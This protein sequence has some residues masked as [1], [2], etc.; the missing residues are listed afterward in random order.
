MSHLQKIDDKIAEMIADLNFSPWKLSGK[1]CEGKK[2]G[3]V[4][5]ALGMSATITQCRYSRY[6]DDRFCYFCEK[7]AQGLF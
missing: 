3:S 4:Q 7:K 1:R 5:G 6:G 2:R